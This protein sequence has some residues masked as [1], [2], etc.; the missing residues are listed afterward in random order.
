MAYRQP[1]PG[2]PTQR[3][4]GAGQNP[5][6]VAAQQAAYE[7]QRRRQ[8][9][10]YEREQQRQR[11]QTGAYSA[12]AQGAGAPAVQP[13]PKPTPLPTDYVYFERS[14][15]GFKKDTLEKAQAAKLKLEHFYQKAVQEAIERNGR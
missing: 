10:H 12:Q 7:E 1:P 5:P 2:A 8:Q 3:P 15:G 6:F 11:D 4:Y 13:A 14:P 9:E